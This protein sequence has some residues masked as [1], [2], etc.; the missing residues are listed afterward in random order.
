MIDVLCMLVMCICAAFIG[1]S[2]GSGS[3]VGGIIGA[4]VGVVLLIALCAVA[5][6]LVRCYYLKT[7]SKYA[8]NNNSLHVSFMPNPSYGVAPGSDLSSD[9]YETIEG[10]RGDSVEMKPNPSYALN[11]KLPQRAGVNATLRSHNLDKTTSNE[12]PYEYV[13]TD[14]DHRKYYGNFDSSY[15]SVIGD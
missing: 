12:D 13:I 3:P 10:S 14:E 4:V 15:L 8:I 2:S 6:L 7:R 9:H 5:L 11:R 1:S